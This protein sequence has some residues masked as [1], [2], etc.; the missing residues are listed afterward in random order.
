MFDLGPA[1]A[2][3]ASQA[4]VSTYSVEAVDEHL[5]PLPY[6]FLLSERQWHSSTHPSILQMCQ[7][8]KFK[9]KKRER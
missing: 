6:T 5:G 4:T 2:V 8:L 1:L 9:K 3:N 7:M